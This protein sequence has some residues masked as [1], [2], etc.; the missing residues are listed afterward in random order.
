MKTQKQIIRKIKEK[1]EWYL[2]SWFEVEAQISKYDDNY[3]TVILKGKRFQKLYQFDTQY[4]DK[5]V[6]IDMNDDGG[7][8]DLDGEA[9]F[10]YLYFTE[11]Q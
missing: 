7:F 10:R 1:V 8:E 5:K 6:Q 3:I 2:D 9:L 11:L 4:K